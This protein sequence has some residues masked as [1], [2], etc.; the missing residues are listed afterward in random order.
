MMMMIIVIMIIQTN[1]TD[2]TTTCTTTTT[3][4]TNNNNNNNNNNNDNPEV[5]LPSDDLQRDQLAVL[6]RLRRC[7]VLW[8]CAAKMDEGNEQL[9]CEDKL[10]S[11]TSSP[12]LWHVYQFTIAPCAEC[13][14]W[15]GACKRA[16][17]VHRR[18]HFDCDEAP[19]LVTWHAASGRRILTPT[20]T[21]TQT[22]T[23][24]LILILILIRLL[25]L[26][27]TINGPCWR[28]SRPRRTCR[29]RGEPGTWPPGEED[30]II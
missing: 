11:D 29:R 17:G 14:A 1:N 18:A 22:L 21:Q 5:V 8:V 4:T 9:K 3:T 27:I 12:L 19:S 26:I 2:N 25:I 13:Y 15:C 16:C 7:H 10:R 20:L 28:T 24:T 23:L 30:Y 6:R